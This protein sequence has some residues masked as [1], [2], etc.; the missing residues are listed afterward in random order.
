MGQKYNQ[1]LKEK[2][3]VSNFVG[4]WINK[5]ETIYF[6][7]ILVIFAPQFTGGI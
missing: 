7:E 3:F 2:T 5:F 4:V 6:L 1:Y